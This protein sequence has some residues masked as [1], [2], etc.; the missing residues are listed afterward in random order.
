MIKGL[1]AAG[2]VIFMGV[3]SAPV[4][5]AAPVLQ[6]YISGATI[7]AGETWAYTG[8]SFDLKV[9]T[10]FPKDVTAIDLYLAVSVPQGTTGT[11]SMSPNASLFSSGADRD[12]LTDVGGL[13]G[14]GSRPSNFALNNHDPYKDSVSDFLYFSLGTIERPS[15]TTTLQ[16][17]NAGGSVETLSNVVGREDTYQI[18]FSGFPELHFDVIGRLAEQ[19]EIKKKGQVVGYETKYLWEMNPPSHDSMAVPPDGPVIPLPSSVLLGGVGLVGLGVRRW[20]VASR[21]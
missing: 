3:L 5:R 15:S 17:Y 4:A 6:A 14:F 11:I 8:N 9:V 16:N 1:W 19:N 18:T 12:L 7:G 21:A 2:S 13:D 10:I 20:W